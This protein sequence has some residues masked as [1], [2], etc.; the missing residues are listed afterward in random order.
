MKKIFKMLF[1]S[2]CLCIMIV[3]CESPISEEPKPQPEPEPTQYEVRVDMGLDEYAALGF[4]TD[5]Q[6]AFFEYNDQNEMVYTHT[7][8]NVFDGQ[9]KTFTA[10]KRSTKIVVKIELTASYGG[11]TKELN[12][13]LAQVFYLE[14][15][16]I[17]LI[18]VDGYA[19]TSEWSPI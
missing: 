3:G 14:P 6:V 16:N 10:N 1:Y 4:N 7:W 17:I 19:R 12:L 11:V 2:L 8:Y 5:L 18:D 9:S 13:F 15:E